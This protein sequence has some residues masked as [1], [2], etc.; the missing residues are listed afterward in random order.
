MGI[1]TLS[2]PKAQDLWVGDV[3]VPAGRT[4]SVDGLTVDMIAQVTLGNLTISPSVADVDDH[5]LTD[6]TG[7]TADTS[8]IVQPMVLSG[9]KTFDFASV[10]TGASSAT[11][12][13]T[14][15]GATLGMYAR[16]SVGV[17]QAGIIL[18][19]WVSAADTVS[20]NVVNLTGGAVDLASTTLRV[21]AFN[22][23]DNL[24]I[25]A[26]TWTKLINMLTGRLAWV[27]YQMRGRVTGM[28]AK[29]AY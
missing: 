24:S 19:A 25:N 1:F 14:V 20:V 22:A 29:G 13:V 4:A 15:T 18:N 7:G 21:Q 3:L 10:A 11:T 8:Y 9:S 6:S 27:E 5:A 16:A 12:T 26:A 2:N 23:A 28:L 17:D